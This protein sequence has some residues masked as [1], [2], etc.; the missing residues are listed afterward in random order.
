MHT[1]GTVM[2]IGGNEDKAGDA[3]ILASFVERAGGADARIIIIP[4]ASAAP[5]ERAA[6]Y[7][8]IFLRF[9]A[10]CVHTVHA[11]RNVSPDDLML[12][13]NASGIFVT[14]GDQDL[15]MKHLRRT[16]CGDAI[17]EAVQ[18]GAVYAGTSAGAAIVSKT[19]IYSADD[20]TLHFGLGLGLVSGVI[21]DQHFT[22]R[23]RLPRLI[24]AAKQHGVTGVGVDEDTVMIFD[25][26]RTSVAGAGAVTIV[27]HESG[28]LQLH[29]LRA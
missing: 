23:A 28:D 22:E 21:I 12:I 9:G 10:A 16:R 13:T 20:G 19:M 7:T 29:V 26:G 4:A 17:I 11:Q 1:T 25:R 14:G 27:H 6:E 24:I 15:L 3:A 8:R 2:A 5:E 18:N